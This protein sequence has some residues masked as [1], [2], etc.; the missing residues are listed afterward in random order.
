MAAQSK[1]LFVRLF[2]GFEKHT[3][4]YKIYQGLFIFPTWSWITIRLHF[5]MLEDGSF[6]YNGLDSVWNL[7]CTFFFLQD[8]SVISMLLAQ[9]SVEVF[10]SGRCPLW[11][12]RYHKSWQCHLERRDSVTG[13]RHSHIP[14]KSC[15]A[16]VCPLSSNSKL[17]FQQPVPPYHSLSDKVTQ[18]WAYLFVLFT[19][20]PDT[21]TLQCWNSRSAFAQ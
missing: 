12:N 5:S 16:P 2:S 4:F 1:V 6:C 11:A 9:A 15:Q 14:I 13:A 17:P 18:D 7:A 3:V 20:W 10:P 21:I 19:C 8:S